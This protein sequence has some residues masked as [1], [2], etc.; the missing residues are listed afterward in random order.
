[1]EGGT[2]VPIFLGGGLNSMKLY[3]ENINFHLVENKHFFHNE[4]VFLSYEIC[5]SIKNSKKKKL[6]KQV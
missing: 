3:S 1:M 6:N 2:L 5:L 4:H